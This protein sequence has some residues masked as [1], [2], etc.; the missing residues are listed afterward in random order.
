[1][2]R[3]NS[4]EIDRELQTVRLFLTEPH[5]CSYITQERATTAFVDP[6][7]QVSV[8]LYQQL[9]EQGFRRS[10]RFHYR[11]HCS[12]CQAC[13]SVRIP[14][15]AFTP[16]RSQKRCAQRNQNIVIE[17]KHQIDRA[18]PYTL[19]EH[20]IARR[21]SDG[22]MYPASPSQFDDFLG[23]RSESTLYLEMRLND[24]L[25]GCAVS[26]RLG[27]SLSAIY[28]YFDPQ[29]SKRSLG[30][31]AILAQL[32]LARQWRLEFVYLGYW[33]ANSNKM[34]YKT[35]FKPLEYFCGQGWSPEPPTQ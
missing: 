14:V 8:A 15:A 5:D 10:G 35:Q 27:N 25:I 29:Q 34:A 21:H 24:Q 11:P 9:A 3:D 19:F 18:E 17:A 26:D 31:L 4:T 16:N 6:E 13:I 28:T 23:S 7:I 33:I 30:T 22:D 32:D 20:Y 2:S 12:N 1:M